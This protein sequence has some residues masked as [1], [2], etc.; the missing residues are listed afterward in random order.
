MTGVVNSTGARTGVVGTTV[1][2]VTAAALSGVLPVGVT[3]GSGLDASNIGVTHFSQWRLTTSFTG[4]QAP[5]TSN[6]EE[7]GTPVGF[8]VK[9]TSMTESSGIF[10]FPATGYWYITFKV[11]AVGANST[12]ARNYNHIYSTHDDSTWADCGVGEN[13]VE[14]GGYPT[15]F[16]N[17]IFD[18]VSTSTHKIRFHCT[19]TNSSHTIHGHAV[20]YISTSMSFLRLGDT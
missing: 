13:W 9:G 5:I 19:H 4:S 15:C 2:T 17:Y 16:N 18:V 8:G 11:R 3:G 14:Y 20:G 12:S 10:T 1:G 6:L 7:A